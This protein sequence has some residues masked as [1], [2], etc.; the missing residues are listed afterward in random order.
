[1]AYRPRIRRRWP[2]RALTVLA[3]TAVAASASCGAPK[4]H[5]VKSSADRTYVRVPHEW[6]LFHENEL[7]NK[8]DQSPEAR[9]QYKRLNW[10]VAFDA[11]PRPSLD[12][13]LSVSDHPTGLVQVSTLLP[14]Q[15]DRFSLSTLRSVLLDLHPLEG[16]AQDSVEV[17]ES[18]DVER[19]GGLHGNEL[20]IN[21]KTPEGRL[22]KWRQVALVDGA[23]RKVHV[24]AISCDAGCYAANEKVIDEVVSSWKVKER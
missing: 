10:S 19:P 6:T 22:V 23:V 12:H 16:E 15:R 4:Y 11:A 21:I 9:D 3:G 13:I 2:G 18:R 17:L 5:Y 24:L 7:V 8:L 20:L 14:E 1:M